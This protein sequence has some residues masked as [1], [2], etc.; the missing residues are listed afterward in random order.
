MYSEEQLGSKQTA[1]LEVTRV[2]ESTKQQYR[3]AAK[4]FYET[5]LGGKPPAPK[6]VEAALV[7]AAA[8]YRPSSWRRL[9]TAIAFV[10]REAGHKAAA[11]Y[12]SK[13]KNPLT[14]QVR[15]AR[16]RSIG[17]EHKKPKERQRRAKGIKLRDTKRLYKHLVSRG[18]KKGAA[19]VLILH[20]LGI[21]PAEIESLR[22]RSDGRVTVYGAKSNMQRG[23]P[24][25]HLQV[26]EQKAKQLMSAL[27]VFKKLKD[28]EVS[29]AQELR[30]TQERVRL[31]AKRLWPRRKVT[32][33][34]YSFRH[35]LG[36]DLKKSGLDRRRI[37]YVMGHAATRSTDVYGFKVSG[38]GGRTLPMPAQ[39]ADLSVVKVNH[40]E[41]PATLRKRA[42]PARRSRP[43]PEMKGSLSYGMTSGD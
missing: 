4:H 43:R 15:I 29:F 14:D 21:R 39:N 10:Q 12:I 22:I 27:R 38:R 35:Q 6:R 41:R 31:A 42:R 34:L 11:D 33:S 8:D 5:R 3:Q 16:L 25:R 36:S 28:P 24:I 9:R 19:I 26:T 20:E 40:T 1:E 7:A 17:I 2:E 32:P 30:R 37:A 18:D 23:I 13:I